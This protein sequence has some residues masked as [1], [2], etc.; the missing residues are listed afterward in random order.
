MRRD[1]IQ[2]TSTWTQDLDIE[3]LARRLQEYSIGYS[4]CLAI[5]YNQIVHQAQNGTFSVLY[6][7]RRKP[8]VAICR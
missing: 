7:T 3:T 4:G 2:Q 6:D 8:T 5:G 1:A